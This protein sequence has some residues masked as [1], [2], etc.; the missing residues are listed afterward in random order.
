MGEQQI[1]IAPTAYN[2]ARFIGHLLKDIKALQLMIEKGMVE[3]DIVRI[4]AEQEFCLTNDQWRPAQNAETLL[5]QIDDPHFTTEL[6][7]YNLE[8]NL[9]PQLFTGAALS[10]ME[11][12]LLE[13]LEKATSVAEKADSKIVLTG[14][15]PTIG[16]P[17]LKEDYLTD[18]PR[19]EILNE[20]LRNLKGAPFH[21]HLKGVDE[22]NIEHQSVLFEACNT[23]FQLHLQIAPDDFVSSY[24]WA[25]AISGPILSVCT[26]SPV[27]LGRELWKE[28][29]I[30][31]FRQSIDIRNTSTALRDEDPRV[32]FGCEWAKGSVVDIF[33]DSIARHKVILDQ[34]IEEDSLEMVQNGQVPKLAALSLH[35]GTIYPWNRACFGNSGN[36]KAHLRIENRYIP[37]G[38]S[39][40][41]EMAN[42]ALWTGIMMGRPEKFNDMAAV[43]DFEEAKANF[44]KAA[45]YGKDAL[46]V[47]EGQHIKAER[48]MLDVFLPMAY[49]GL[50]RAGLQNREIEAY[51]GVIRERIGGQTGSSWMIRNYRKLKKHYTPDTA[52]RLLTKAMHQKQQINTPVDQWSDVALSE[53]LQT[54]ATKVGHIMTTKLFTV[55]ED[56]LV[57]L[58]LQIMQWKD[59]HHVPV[60]NDSGQLKGLLTWTH[61]QNYQEET[62]K[63]L[64]TVA[65]LMVQDVYTA[66]PSDKIADALQLMKQ[67]MVGCLPVVQKGVVVGIITIKDLQAFL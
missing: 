31:L 23:S 7:K 43:M 42:L 40:K 1:S 58:P 8:I 54:A 65:D 49:D 60:I 15:L 34:P 48:L 32:S 57:A 25:Q 17:Q 56:D 61:L 35:N 30:A 28:T 33:K 27:L 12:Q 10:D 11:N 59:I 41:D 29:R 50:R 38:P 64:A 36:G 52:L 6:A 24:N 39:V 20:T 26:N 18:R 16:K 21:L 44:V 62:Q 4:G 2:K 19:Y 67:H 53:V 14:I 66:K 46:L 51:L 37:S 47:W 63:E 55:R 13:L 22:L 9:D 45:R 3:D 5:E